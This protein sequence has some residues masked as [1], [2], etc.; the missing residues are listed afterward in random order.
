LTQKLTSIL[1]YTYNLWIS[2]DQPK[3]CYY[4]SRIIS[5]TT[6]HAPLQE[7][8]ANIARSFDHQY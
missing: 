2:D 4:A 3:S 7:T 5:D 6:V 8:I 1:I